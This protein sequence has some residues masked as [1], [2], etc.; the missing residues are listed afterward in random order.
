[1]DFRS[2]SAQPPAPRPWKRVLALVFLLLLMILPYDP[3]DYTLGN[4][5]R[6][7]VELPVLIL[8]L[9]ATPERLRPWM[10]GLLAAALGLVAVLKAADLATYLIFARDFNAFIHLPPVF[11]GLNVLSGALGKVAAGAVVVLLLLLFAGLLAIMVWALKAAVPDSPEAR[12]P[13]L[14][15]FAA[16]AL[17]AYVALDDLDVKDEGIPIASSEVTS[18]VVNQ[19][20]AHWQSYDDRNRFNLAMAEEA[21]KAPPAERLLSGLGKTDVLF[22]LIESYGRSTIESP[23]HSDEIGR[24]LADFQKE[25][26]EKGFSA[27]SGWLQSS[28]YGGQSWLAQSTLMSGLRIDRSGRYDALLTSDHP[29]LVSDFHR[30]GWRTVA[31]MPALKNPWTEQEFFKFDQVYRAPELGYH[32]QPFNWITMPDQYTLSEVERRELAPAD[33]KPVMAEMALISSHAPWTPIPKLVPWN[34]V[35]DGSVFDETVRVGGAPADVWRSTEKIRESYRHSIAY[36]LD[37]IK[38]FVLTYGNDDLMLVVLGD[39]QPVPFVIGDDPIRDVPVHVIARRPDLLKQIDGWGWT[40]GM[41]P[42]ASATSTP[43][44]DMRQRILT[45][46]TPPQMSQEGHGSTATR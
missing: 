2:L 28:T 30:A 35:G 44:E 16:A 24:V 8:L 13:V 40:E 33:R 46:F 17:V 29:T 36:V 4:F 21:A 7:P 6:L 14:G 27:R 25:I 41:I 5:L 32:G 23:L 34:K 15:I 18:L 22:I 43:L 3:N 37:T 45:T 11:A 20:V 1:M 39:H 26:G 42:A 10:R 31:V 19:A 38:S 12:N 9:V